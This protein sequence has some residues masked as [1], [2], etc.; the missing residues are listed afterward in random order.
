MPGQP[1]LRGRQGSKDLSEEIE[2]LWADR[3]SSVA[4]QVQQHLADLHKQLCADHRL[5]VHGLQIQ[6]DKAMG[7]ELSKD[8]SSSPLSRRSPARTVTLGMGRAGLPRRSGTAE[9]SH[10]GSE[11][12]EA[13]LSTFSLRSHMKS[14]NTLIDVW[15]VWKDDAEGADLIRDMAKEKSMLVKAQQ[16]IGSESLNPQL[17]RCGTS[18]PEV[19]V[20]SWAIRPSSLKFLVW[21]F[22]FLVVLFYDCVSFPLSAFN[23]EHLFVLPNMVAASFWT[24]DFILSFFVGYDT[25]DGQ[26][27]TRLVKTAS[28]YART[29]MLPDLVV[30]V[31]D[32]IMLASA[33]GS[34]LEDTGSTNPAGFARIG[35]SVR[36]MRIMRV[37]RLLR[38]RRFQEALHQFDE[39]I[40]IQYFSIIQK[41][42]MN[43]V[44]I[45]LLSHFIGCGWYAIGMEMLDENV[46]EASWVSANGLVGEQ[47]MYKYLTSLHWSITQ[48]TPGSMN[49]QPVNSF[50]RLYSVIV[51]VLGMVVFSSTVSSITAATNNLKDINAVYK[52]QIWTLRRYFREQ[53]I[54]AQLTSR[55]LRYTESIVK[56]KYQKV[57]VGQVKIMAMLPQIL[58]KEVNLEIYE[59]HLVVHPLFQ[60]LGEVN[61]SFMQKICS[62]A[63]KESALDKGEMVFG[64]GQV[65][66]AMYFVTL[67]VLEYF[68]S[69]ATFPNIVDKKMSFCEA[70][71]W[72]PWV[73]QGR[74]YTRTESTVIAVDAKQFH[75]VAQSFS[76]DMELLKAYGRE[77]VFSMNEVAGNFT[78]EEEDD[79]ELS[80]LFHSEKAIQVLPGKRAFE[81]SSYA[82][83]ANSYLQGLQGFN[84]VRNLISPTSSPT[85]GSK[86]APE[87]HAYSSGNPCMSTRVLILSWTSRTTTPRCLTFSIATRQRWRAASP[88]LSG[89]DAKHGAMPSAVVGVFSLRRRPILQHLGGQELCTITYR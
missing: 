12:A 78:P 27:E 80:D 16:Q 58:T 7:P 84:V 79:E 45:L 23:I 17:L 50:E 2:N 21:N 40:N 69:Q 39:F 46:I 42:I 82:I 25:A 11:D 48:F 41:L 55:V 67:G 29:W 52:H 43:M 35:K 13:D 28:R 86:L 9:I 68:F 74:M 64:P 15:P 33:L 20:E 60:S 5:A 14:G 38:L 71:L 4:Q 34:Q 26:V 77:F 62:N 57:D 73:H 83:S 75:D 19:T 8:G 89:R 36:Y 3:L 37:M 66:S 81:E 1:E 51:L 59:K 44:W 61:V 53:K 56:P 87:D 70:V 47:L 24:A 32:W 22:L 6:A 18:L 85:L 76:A 63:L 88:R 10:H 54:S 65:C 30:I 49:V 31:V 72:T